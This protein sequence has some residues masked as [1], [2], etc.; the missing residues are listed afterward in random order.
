MNL[1]RFFALTIALTLAASTW[2]E[3]DSKPKQ[4]KAPPSCRSGAEK[5][6]ERF[7]KKYDINGDGQ[8]DENEKATMKKDMEACKAKQKHSKQ[9]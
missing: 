9:P 2:A 1:A 7:L 4:D 8:L 6:N 5:C 3:T